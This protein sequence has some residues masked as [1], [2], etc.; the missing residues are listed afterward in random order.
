MNQAIERLH[1]A[2]NKTHWHYANRQLVS[3][4]LCEFLYEEMLTTEI[5]QQEDNQ[6]VHTL[7]IS[8]S[9]SYRFS[10]SPRIFGNWR[11][12]TDSVTRYENNEPSPI[13]S[14]S[15]FIR[16]TY[17]LIGIGGLTL[18]HL[19]RELNNTLVADCHALSLQKNGSSEALLSLP[20]HELEGF[21]Q[22]HPWFVINKGRLGFS[23]ADYLRHAP[24][25]QHASALTWIAVHKQQAL[26]NTISHLDY[27][28]VINQEL[29]LADRTRFTDKL[30]A[31]KLSP[32]DYYF[33][34]IHDWQWQNQLV[35]LFSQD[36]AHQ[37]IIYLGVSE[38][39]YLPTQSVRTFTNQSQGHKYQVK[40]PLSI[41]N[42]AVYRGLPGERTT[43]APLLSEWLR[44][45]FSADAFF[46]EE[47]RL[48]LLGEIASIDYPH[49]DYRH[50]EKIPYQY[51]ELLGVIWRENVRTYLKENETAI[52]MASLIHVDAQQKPFVCALV[53]KSGL[54]LAEWLK[55][56]FAV[57]I[58]P[59]L[60]WLY[61]YGLVFSP[62]GENTLLIMDNYRPV[63]LVIKDFIDDVNLSDRDL[64]ETADLPPPLRD[65]L[66]KVSDHQ[67][68][69]F[70][71]TG[72]FVVLYRYL[73]DILATHAH[74]AEA[75]FWQQVHETILAYQKKYP[76]LQ[77]R[78]EQFD[79]LR[80]SFNKMCL[81]RLRLLSV[82]YAD[83]DDRPKVDTITPMNNPVNADYLHAWRSKQS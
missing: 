3:K 24:E 10:A 65:V 62:H 33:M 14:V 43:L 36:M 27:E 52:T 53:E 5:S 29:S 32:H 35:T 28:T 7:V 78:F 6:Y 44:Q 69:Q 60:H 74:Y 73:S 11:I 9:L 83:Y 64:P 25:M 22:G 67:L 82:G 41:F 79:L 50:L 81:N 48:I 71:H 55:T 23:Y 63:G 37:D 57:T 26:F 15:Q 2:L 17:A 20:N 47:C 34:P 40:L 49:R 18:G 70:I 45:K 39:H 4:M 38:D 61:R 59:L 76:D 54:S 75:D 21:M 51:K 66:L 72:L 56:F 30:R 19:L 13:L 68:T 46:A 16:D 31:E 42:T 58:P 1:Q 8:P 12:H 77:V 80:P